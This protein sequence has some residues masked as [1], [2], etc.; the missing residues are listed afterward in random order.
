MILPSKGH[1]QP[2]DNITIKRS[3]ALRV[4][5]AADSLKVAKVEIGLLKKD[6]SNT[7]L[8]VDQLK[9]ALV[10]AELADS[11][12]QKNLQIALQKDS[13]RLQH[14]KLAEDN[15]AIWQKKYK[16]EARLR[17][18]TGFAGVV[19]TIAAVVLPIVIK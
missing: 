14:I 12:S 17:A 1:S 13:L 9:R 16:K 15:A 4:L 2:T 11:I 7:M 5:A 3:D 18:W 19:T 6:L 10:L 8:A